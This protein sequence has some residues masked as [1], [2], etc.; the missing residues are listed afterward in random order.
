MERS[1]EQCGRKLNP[2]E[3]LLGPVCGECTR[4]N[5]QAICRP[6]QIE[7]LDDWENERERMGGNGNQREK[8]SQDR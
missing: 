8:D 1:C 6:G 5:H 7:T 4:E 2:V 3:V